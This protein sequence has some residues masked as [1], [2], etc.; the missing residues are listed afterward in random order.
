MEQD[1]NNIKFVLLMIFVHVFNQFN[2][3]EQL[4]MKVLFSSFGNKIM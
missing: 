3:T 1:L 2:I 4:E